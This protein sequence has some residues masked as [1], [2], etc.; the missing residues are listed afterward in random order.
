M[1]GFDGAG[2]GSFSSGTQIHQ[3]QSPLPCGTDELPSNLQRVLQNG[4]RPYLWQ[5]TLS[6]LTVREQAVSVRGVS[7]LLRGCSDV[8]YMKIFWVN[9]TIYVPQDVDSLARAMKL[10]SHLKKQE[11]YV[12]GTT[13]VVVLGSGVYEVI[14]SLSVPCDNLSFVG[15]GERE[16]IVGGGL[17]VE[18]GR[19][20]SFEGLTV[21]DS[22]DDGL[23]ALGAGT[24]MV[25]QNV[26]ME[27]CQRTGVVV[28]DGANFVATGCQF[29]QN[30]GFG[31][32]VYGSTTTAR[33]TNCTSH[34]NKYAGVYAE[35]G[36]VVDLMGDE[37][38]VH[39][40]EG[41]GCAHTTVAA[42]STSTTTLRSQ[43]HVPRKQ[44][45][46]KYL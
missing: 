46:K 9:P 44:E 37:T 2:G 43:R 11:G 39:E 14:G 23:R 15:Q 18:N 1:N 32:Y 36:A 6:F 17:V 3:L 19:K 16:T 5:R 27:K 38:S 45:R 8:Y 13:M 34:H 25:L 10:C 20:V 33:L 41:S 42:P 28:R 31:V 35:C 24:M 26:T 21:K 22:S 30:G 7:R 40:N 12:E 29:H 4:I